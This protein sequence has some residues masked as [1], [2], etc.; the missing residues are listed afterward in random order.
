MKDMTSSPLTFAPSYLASDD[1]KF[2]LA[3]VLY[4]SG[5]KYETQ[6]RGEEPST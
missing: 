6:G 5:F 1:T 2:S 3:L 4:I